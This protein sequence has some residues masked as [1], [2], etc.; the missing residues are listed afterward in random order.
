MDFRLKYPFVRRG[1]G[2]PGSHHS[3]SIQ[4]SSDSIYG[5]DEREPQ[6]PPFAKPENSQ[7]S[8]FNGKYTPINLQPAK[9]TEKTKVRPKRGTLHSD[10]RCHCVV[11]LRGFSLRVPPN[12]IPTSFELHLAAASGRNTKCDG[13]GDNPHEDLY[14]VDTP[15]ESSFNGSSTVQLF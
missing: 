12:V 2:P 4:H 7:K 14:L 13:R 3:N 6:Q 8:N 15:H 1:F 9:I 11:A 5:R 10:G